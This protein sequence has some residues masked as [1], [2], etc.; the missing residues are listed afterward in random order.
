MSLRILFL[1]FISKRQKLILP[2]LQV[3]RSKDE[4]RQPVYDFAFVSNKTFEIVE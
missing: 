3:P 2:P 1:D 4:M